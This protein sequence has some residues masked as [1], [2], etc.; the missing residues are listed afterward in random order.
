MC[1][2][3]ILIYVGGVLITALVLTSPPNVWSITPTAADSPL[4]LSVSHALNI[5]SRASAWLVVMGELIAQM[6]F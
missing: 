4:A 3:L 2:G 5:A 6:Y 1:V